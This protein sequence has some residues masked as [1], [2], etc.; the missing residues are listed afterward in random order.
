MLSFTLPNTVIA[1]SLPDNVIR[2]D[3]PLASHF[4]R[5]GHGGKP[6]TCLTFCIFLGKTHWGGMGSLP[7]VQTILC[8]YKARRVLAPEQG[9]AKRP[10]SVVRSPAVDDGTGRCSMP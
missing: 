1:W 2:C 8:P 10:G 3:L 4:F 7:S 6:V 9:R 5:G